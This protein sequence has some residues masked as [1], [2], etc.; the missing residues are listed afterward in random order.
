[1]WFGWLL[2]EFVGP[3]AGCVGGLP[4]LLANSELEAAAAEEEEEEG[5]EEEEV[6]EEQE[7]RR[8]GGA[9]TK[10]YCELLV[11][12]GGGGGDTLGCVVGGT[13]RLFGAACF[14]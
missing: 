12:R 11:G 13:P 6:E 4:A 9:G 7:F 2:L 3:F 14:M 1:M 5:K 8:G 10:E